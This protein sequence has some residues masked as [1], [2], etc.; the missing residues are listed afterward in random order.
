MTPSTLN[1]ESFSTCHSQTL[2]DKKGDVKKE[3]RPLCSLC[4][5]F[6]FYLICPLFLNFNYYRRFFKKKTIL[7]R[8]LK[9]VFRNL[10][11]STKNN[12]DNIDCYSPLPNVRGREVRYFFSSLIGLEGL[13]SCA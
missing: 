8:S 12:I 1:Q 7:F 2:N 4:E 11:K 9:I 6:K 10:S 13:P 3:I 5:V